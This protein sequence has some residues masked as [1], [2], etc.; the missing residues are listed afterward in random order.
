MDPGYARGYR[1]LYEQHWWWRARERYLVAQLGRLFP[2]GVTGPI[3]DVGCGDGLLFPRLRELGEVEGVECDPTVITDQGRSAGHIHEVAFDADFS[4]GRLYGL[5]LMLDM[6][7]HL[8]EPGAALERARELLAPGGRVVVTV[9][10]YRILWTSLDAVN[11]HCTRFRP[12]ELRALAASAGLR[13]EELRHFFHWIPPAKILVRVLE[14]FGVGST[15]SPR[16]PPEP[17]NRALRRLCCLEQALLGRLPLP[18]GG[19]LFAVLT[20]LR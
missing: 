8:D 19:S 17:L 14:A 5:V 4:P 18:F 2:R 13:V 9:P 7:E 3:L 12:G 15:G 20:P 10:A 11:R 6:L 16:I 1:Q